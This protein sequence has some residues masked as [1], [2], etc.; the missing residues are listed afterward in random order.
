MTQYALYLRKSRADLDAEARGEGETLAKHRAALTDMAKRRGLLIVREYA[1]I[2]SGDTI[3]ARPQMQALLADVKAGMYAGVIV[4]DVDRLGR[5]DSIDQEIIKLTFAASHTLIITPMRDIDPANPTDDDML[6]F[7]MFMARFEYKKISARMKQGKVRSAAAGNFVTGTAPFGYVIHKDG[8]KLTLRPDDAS[9]PIVRMIYDW[10][11]RGEAGYAAIA[12]R[13]ENMGVRTNTGHPFTVMAVKRILR[14]PVYI[15]RI[16]YGART[17]VQVI[18]DGRRVKQRTRIKPP[19]SVDNAH[20]AIVSPDVWQAVQDRA[21]LARYRSPVNTAATMQNP[22]AGLVRC[23][24]C[25][26]VM[27]RDM[28]PRGPVL[29]C[30]TRGCPTVAA[31][32]DTVETA[33]LEI[34]ASWCADYA[35]PMTRPEPVED[36]QRR[37]ALRRQL[38]TVA[39]QLTRAMELVETGVYTASEYVTRREALEGRKKALTAELDKLTHKTPEQA[40]AAILPALR[41][42]LDAYPYAETAEQKNALLRSVVARVDYH[43]TQAA[44]RNQSSADFM[45]LDVWPI[46]G[47]V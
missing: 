36:V 15:G 3:A 33:L 40:R 28:S 7:S 13:L 8:G 19:V 6:D 26:N 11:A 30:M 47:S 27:L 25:G 35:E 23:A 21:S 24:E 42:V 20:P 14:S 45:T 43:K 41:R 32:L 2:V 18:E 10:Y 46:V 31:Y 29:R 37:D 38:D 16:E 34:L 17:S 5:G 4:N 1:E 44:K 22:L 9:A 12:T 39:A